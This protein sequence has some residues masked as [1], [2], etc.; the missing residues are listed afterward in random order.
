MMTAEQLKWQ[1]Y[2]APG[3]ARTRR[4]QRGPGRRGRDASGEGTDGRARPEKEKTQAGEGTTTEGGAAGNGNTASEG[5]E[6]LG[7]MRRFG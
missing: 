4:V 7:R 6:A 1:A 5:V 2:L 3:L